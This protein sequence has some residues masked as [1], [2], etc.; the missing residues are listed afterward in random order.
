M[1]DEIDSY[2]RVDTVARAFAAGE[3]VVVADDDDRENEGDL[4]VAASLCTPGLHHPPHVGHRVRAAFGRASQT[5]APRSHVGCE[6]CAAWHCRYRL[7]RL[8]PWVNHQH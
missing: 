6:R 2:A 1:S 3:I 4:F 8:P 7:G 5:R